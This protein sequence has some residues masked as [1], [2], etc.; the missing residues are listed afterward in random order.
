MGNTVTIGLPAG[1]EPA[2]PIDDPTFGETALAPADVPTGRNLP[3]ASY[4]VLTSDLETAILKGSDA[5]PPTP[6]P[7]I[8]ASFANAILD[9]EVEGT[10]Q[11]GDSI[12]VTFHNVQV[13][14]QQLSEAYD[15]VFIVNDTIFG[16][17]YDEVSDLN[18]K[19]APQ[20]LGNVTVM[21]DSVAAESVVNFMVNYKATT[22][23]AAA[24]AYGR[25][26]VDLPDAWKDANTIHEGPQT[27]DA[28][29]EAYVAVTKSSGVVLA[30]GSPSVSA[31]D[32]SI[33]IDVD[34]MKMGQSVTLTVN[35]L[36]IAEL[37]H[38][39]LGDE[40][41]KM[42]LQVTVFSDRYTSMDN[43]DTGEPIKPPE[44]FIPQVT[45]AGGSTDQPTVTVT[46]RMLGTATVSKTS[47]DAG[48]KNDL[49]ITY[50]FAEAMAANGMVDIKLPGDWDGGN[51]PM[52][53]QIGGAVT[54][55]DLPTADDLEGMNGYVYL[56]RLPTKLEGTRINVINEF[57]ADAFV[58]NSGGSLELSGVTTTDG[59]II[60]ITLGGARSKTAH[61]SLTIKTQRHN[62][63]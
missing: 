10:M 5:D 43:R 14:D 60:R 27:G 61:L 2:Y 18:V 63:V 49:R 36:K 30:T 56:N 45:T 1:W 55:D 28:A 32:E 3:L 53:Y 12:T 50:R 13:E 29:K 38:D 15:A 51:A 20:K 8:Q 31:S 54:P 47:V 44:I 48:S 41:E 40:V 26:V 35:N 58:T 24:G 22:D 37:E 62:G 21:T 19:V 6:L 59:W 33:Y 46:R 17:D 25:I 4:V 52:P 42:L 16:T 39:A 23:L 57:D 9:I 7:S 34:T 11:E